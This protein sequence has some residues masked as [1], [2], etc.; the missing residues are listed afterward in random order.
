MNKA[1]HTLKL[2]YV[3]NLVL[4]ILETKYSMKIIILFCYVFVNN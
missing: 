1:L 4:T 3:N 2:I